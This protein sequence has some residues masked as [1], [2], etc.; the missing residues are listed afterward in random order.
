LVGWGDIDQPTIRREGVNDDALLIH[1][2]SHHAGA[3]RCEQSSRW[4][5]AWILNRYAITGG[6]QHSSD[7]V[8]G[9][10]GTVRDNNIIG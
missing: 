7:D 5:V 2:H 3:E 8:N 6:Q 4:A 10:L 9:L 1:G